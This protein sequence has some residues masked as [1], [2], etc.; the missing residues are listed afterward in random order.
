[1]RTCGLIASTIA[2]TNSAVCCAVRRSPL[3]SLFVRD[4]VGLF[5]NDFE[6]KL[7]LSAKKEV[8]QISVVW[9]T[10]I[11]LSWPQR[12]YTMYF[13]HSINCREPRCKQLHELL[14]IEVVLTTDAACQPH[15]KYPLD[16]TLIRSRNL[17]YSDRQ[18]FRT[19]PIY[20]YM[21]LLI[22]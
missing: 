17:K 6:W 21:F 11:N 5:E 3:R 22:W 10:T 15:F 8:I 9:T 12:R 4:A 16:Y 2:M 18:G 20:I 13:S 7:S 19:K 1:M 14:I